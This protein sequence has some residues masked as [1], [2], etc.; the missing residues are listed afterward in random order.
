MGTRGGRA[1]LYPMPES[2]FKSL[3]EGSG[4]R[5]IKG[6]AEY[7]GVD[8]KV[9][10]R[11]LHDPESAERLTKINRQALFEKTGLDMF[12]PRSKTGLDP[13]TILPTVVLADTVPKSFTLPSLLADPIPVAPVISEVPPLPEQPVTPALKTVRD[14]LQNATIYQTLVVYEAAMSAASFLTILK[15]LVLRG[16]DEARAHFVETLGADDFERL[17]RCVAALTSKEAWEKITAESGFRRL[18]PGEFKEGK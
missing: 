8:R 10:E 17:R 3:M 2:P 16:T 18:F 14:L 11:L 5:T 13:A 6:F 1:I 4:F 9:V 15:A 7:L 12:Q